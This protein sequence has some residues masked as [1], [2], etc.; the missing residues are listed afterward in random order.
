MTL[1]ATAFILLG[2]ATYLAGYLGGRSSA[3]YDML[4]LK[5]KL[6]RAEL[7]KEER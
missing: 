1:S 2:F 4:E 3:K 6:Q 5:M 7:S